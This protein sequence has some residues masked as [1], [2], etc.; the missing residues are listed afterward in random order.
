MTCF[1]FP[2]HTSFSQTCPTGFVFGEVQVG[3]SGGSSPPGKQRGLGRRYAPQGRVLLKAGGPPSNG[4]GAGPFTLT[5]MNY[6]AR[7]QI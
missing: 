1:V 5:Y 7:L 2:E 3:G 4:G 6:F